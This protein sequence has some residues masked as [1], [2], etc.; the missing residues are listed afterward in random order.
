MSDPIRAE[1]FA[2]GQSVLRLED[3]RLV[4]GLGRYSDDVSLPRQTHAVVLRSPH[5]HADIRAIETAAARAVPGVVAILT[6]ADVAAAGLGHLPTDRTR[7][8]RD[9]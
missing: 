1:K 6:G 8:R 7:K 9:G 4:Q 2:I 5:A 3:P